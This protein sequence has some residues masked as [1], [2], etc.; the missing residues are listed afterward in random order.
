M[1]VHVICT[2]EYK[3]TYMI[4]KN[5][6]THSLT[7]IILHREI[8]DDYP[9]LWLT[10]LNTDIVSKPEL[11]IGYS[12]LF[13]VR[14]VVTVQCKI[15]SGRMPGLALSRKSSTSKHLGRGNFVQA[16]IFTW[17]NDTCSVRVLVAS[18]GVCFN[19]DRHWHSTK[20]SQI[21]SRS[22]YCHFPFNTLTMFA[23]N[24][25]L[26]STNIF[27]FLSGYFKSNI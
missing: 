3:H 11:Q 6:C 20:F 9:H 4:K 5:T 18:G 24:I 1:H 27:L 8:S 15:I 13:A 14:I 12:F 23:L 21:D 19:T 25:N 10:G 16:V 26:I 2:C 17:L 22:N 7:Y